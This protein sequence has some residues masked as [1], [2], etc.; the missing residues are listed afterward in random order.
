MRT[1]DNS[2]KG[3]FFILFIVFA[4]VVFCFYNQGWF[5]FGKNNTEQPKTEEKKVETPE[6]KNYGVKMEKMNE[7]ANGASIDA[8]YPSFGN[9][10][11][12]SNIKAVIDAKVKDFKDS[13][14]SSPDV[15]NTDQFL[16][17]SYVSSK[18][19]REVFSIKFDVVYGGGIHPIEDVECRTYNLDN[20]KEI[21]LS[22]VFKENSSYLN[23]ISE[24]VYAELI[25]DK[26]VDPSWAKQ[27]TSPKEE[28]FKNF[29]LEEKNI[30]FYFAPGIVASN[31]S[32]IREVRIPLSSLKMFLNSL[33]VN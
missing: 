14:S 27:G 7:K 23:K 24:L 13:L 6:V 25:K 30:V 1:K 28:N 3:L 20:S 26:N 18:H 19:S 33:F 32:G 29:V 11:V 12:D 2:N 9:G 10:T 22:D 5:G 15:D 21:N 8:E 16:N 4:I 31:S 17:I